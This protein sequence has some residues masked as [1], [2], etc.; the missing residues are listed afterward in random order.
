MLMSNNS[1]V[2]HNKI[3]RRLYVVNIDLIDNG[4]LE[5]IPN[6]SIINFS[7]EYNYRDNFF[8]IIKLDLTINNYLYNLILN[9]KNTIKFRIKLFSYRKKQKKDDTDIEIDKKLIINDK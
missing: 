3:Q 2:D 1:I 9:N 5:S 4:I 7:I 6:I 8:P